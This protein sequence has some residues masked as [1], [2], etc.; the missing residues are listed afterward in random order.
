VN[1][2]ELW[3]TVL[4][5]MV[6]IS[7]P[8]GDAADDG[9]ILSSLLP[10]PSFLRA[11]DPAILL[12][13]G[14]RGAGKTALFDA[15][16]SGGIDALTRFQGRPTDGRRSVVALGEEHWPP[17][18]VMERLLAGATPGEAQLFWLVL[19]LQGLT[20]RAF[21]TSED[22]QRV[23]AQPS[24]AAKLQAARSSAEQLFGAVDRLDEELRKKGH[25]LTVCYDQLDKLMP[26]L[27]GTSQ[28]IG[29]LFSLWFSQRR[30]WLHIRPK[31]FLRIDLFDA[32]QT[33][34]PDGS[35][36]FAGHQTELVW[37]RMQ[38]W[39]MWVKR[40]VN[41][42]PPPRRWQVKTWMT[43]VSPNLT[44][45]ELPDLGL[46]PH[47]GRFDMQLH[48]F[49]AMLRSE[50]RDPGERVIAP[51]IY[52]L[53]GRY[54][55]S[56]PRKGDSFNWVPE[57]AEDA[58]Q[59]LLP[60]SFLHILREAAK[61]AQER[62]PLPAGEA[63]PLRPGD[64]VAGLAKASELR[65]R[66]LLD[67]DPWIEQVRD[68]LAGLEVPAPEEEWLRRLAVRWLPGDPD[69]A[70]STLPADT[71]PAQVL[72]LLCRRGV[73][74]PR[75]NGLYSVPDIYRPALKLKRRGGPKRH[76]DGP[77]T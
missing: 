76:V 73:V 51:L 32:V 19:L 6:D 53:V 28:P 46:V 57:H 40:M 5:A 52:D 66:D 72:A 34:F 47:E 37:D 65:L 10:T 50:R 74:Q 43:Q 38:V 27:P 35:K 11:L 61:S 71:E 2:R 44:F 7:A 42:G 63:C 23:L 16:A 75:S 25:E 17:Q 62:G 77:A 60:R 4:E 45:E 70:R 48:L 68:A 22:V 31:I 9:P 1:K 36:F 55:G 56:G 41:R 8:S 26:T 64:V 67:E 14:E 30:R 29:A 18:P 21:I 58:N 54:M 33:A 69:R 49:E 20:E 24:M 3:P 13:L 12:V 59:R 15:L 39:R